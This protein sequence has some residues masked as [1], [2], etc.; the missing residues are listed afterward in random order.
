[1]SQILSGLPH[2]I[3]ALVLSAAVAPLLRWANQAWRSI[4]VGFLAAVIGGGLAT[5]IFVL[6]SPS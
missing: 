4:T 6:I 2:T 3:L 5:M 1:M